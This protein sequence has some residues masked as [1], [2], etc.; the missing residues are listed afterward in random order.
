VLKKF[1]DNEAHL[2][3]TAKLT[4][5]DATNHYYLFQ[6]IEM[7]KDSSRGTLCLA[8]ASQKHPNYE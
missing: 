1:T 4:N 2:I 5:V 6:V 3:R 7:M 8:Q